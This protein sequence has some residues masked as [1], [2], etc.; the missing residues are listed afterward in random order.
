MEWAEQLAPEHPT[1]RHHQAGEDNGDAHL[2]NLLDAIILVMILQKG[3]QL[4]LLLDRWSDCHTQW[5]PG[6]HQKAANIM[7]ARGDQASNGTPVAPR[8]QLEMFTVRR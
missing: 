5:S 7:A 1:Y 3:E 8:E 2:K 4:N 6:V